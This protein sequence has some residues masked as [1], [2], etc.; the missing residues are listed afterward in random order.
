L[1]HKS[2]TNEFK[3]E[4]NVD[5]F[6]TNE[7]LFIMNYFL[8]ARRLVKFVIWSLWDV[9]MMSFEENDLKCGLWMCA[10]PTTPRL[11]TQLCQ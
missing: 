9:C 10:T 1:P 4:I 5:L 6:S 7:A 8:E 3:R 2:T 11:L